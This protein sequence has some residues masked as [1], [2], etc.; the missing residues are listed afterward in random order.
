MAPNLKSSADTNLKLLLEV[1]DLRQGSADAESK[2]L[3][4][5]EKRPEINLSWRQSQTSS[6]SKHSGVKLSWRRGYQTFL[7][8]WN[9]APVLLKTFI[10]FYSQEL[11]FKNRFLI[12]ILDIVIVVFYNRGFV[13]VVQVL[14]FVIEVWIYLA[15]L[16]ISSYI[17]TYLRFSQ[18]CHYV[19]SYKSPSNV[20]W[21]TSFFCAR[22]ESSLCLNLMFK[23]ASDKK[24]TTKS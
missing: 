22:L 15:V 14:E 8:Q 23:I 21:I 10:T 4:L 1:S 19:V 24:N 7:Q 9:R 2:I 18:L 17:Q 5:W 20:I 16:N 3:I 11:L 13:L 12:S 6:G